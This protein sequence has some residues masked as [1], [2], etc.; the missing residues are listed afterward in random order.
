MRKILAVFVITILYV[1]PL[2]V[3]AQRGSAA[4]TKAGKYEA[5][6][7][8]DAVD[9]FKQTN[10]E[11][12]NYKSYEAHYTTKLHVQF[13][14]TES[15]KAIRHAPTT[16]IVEPL[17]PQ[18]TGRFSYSHSGE[19]HHVSNDGYDIHYD[20]KEESGY[21]GVLSQAGGI[22]TEF[23]DTG[24]EMLNAGA[25]AGGTGNGSFKRTINREEYFQE[26]G[27]S[28]MQA[29]K[30]KAAPE[31]DT[32]CQ[33]GTGTGPLILRVKSASGQ[34][35]ETACSVDFPITSGSFNVTTKVLTQEE[36]DKDEGTWAGAKF[37]GSF[38]SGKYSITLAKTIKPKSWQTEAQNG[39]NTYS[40][41]LSFGV[42]LTLAGAVAEIFSPGDPSN[43]NLWAEVLMPD[44]KLRPAVVKSGSKNCE[45]K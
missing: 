14:S 36:M 13:V 24:D 28:A 10:Y 22:D 37:I 21:A 18:T 43:S 11:G 38:A 7:I 26:P 35:P 32:D 5:T 30:R 40:E 41:T 6:V 19:E 15:V 44:D 16:S 17:Q 8:Y 33:D 12:S 27:T 4:Q 29:K 2:S 25:G 45:S 39:T 9:E 23:P 20:S 31:I 42:N 1:L 3:M 34:P